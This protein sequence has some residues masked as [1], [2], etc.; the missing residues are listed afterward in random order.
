MVDIVFFSYDA[1]TR[2]GFQIS[3]FPTSELCEFSGAQLV[4]IPDNTAEADAHLP[5]DVSQGYT[6]V[7]VRTVDTYVVIVAV[8]AA[9]RLNIDELW[10]IFATERSFRF[11]AAHD[12]SKTLGPNKC[13]ALP[14]S[15]AFCS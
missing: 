1:S 3:L 4:I 13:Q 15:N 12:I 2:P 14:Y 8:M 9:Q 10:F 11:L 6:K 5:D 7:S